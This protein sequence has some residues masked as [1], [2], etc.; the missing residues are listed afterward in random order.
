MRDTPPSM[1]AVGDPAPAL[2]LPDDTDTTRD[3]AAERG[4]KV[5]VFFYPTDFT[6]GCSKEVCGFRDSYAGFTDAGAVVW[7]VSRLDTASKAAFKAKHG[8]PFPLLADEDHAVAER[9]GVW[10][11]KNVHGKTSM[12][13]KRAT[14]L[15]DE[16]GRIAH[17]WPSVKPEGHAEEVLE[18]LRGM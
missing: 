3:L 14:F 10:V 8:L 15:I 13:I 11:E 12:G 5:V 9:Y 7:G 16:E 2:S 17:V 18:T 1:P 4:R 6:D